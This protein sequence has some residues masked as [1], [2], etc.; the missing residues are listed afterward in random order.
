MRWIR[1][2]ESKR[3]RPRLSVVSEPPAA[4]IQPTRT[5]TKLINVPVELMKV[6][7]KQD[8]SILGLQLEEGDGKFLVV[9]G[10]VADGPFGS[11]NQIAQ[12]KEMIFYWI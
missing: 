9:K 6:T 1:R 4:P 11:N 12:G 5:N 2:R 3:Q 10:I 8:V 7:G